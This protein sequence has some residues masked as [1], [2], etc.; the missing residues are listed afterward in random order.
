M[1]KNLAAIKTSIM[2]LKRIFIPF[3]FLVWLSA[4][5]QE[6]KT[7]VSEDG[8]STKPSAAQEEPFEEARFF[9]Y[10]G[11]GLG[12]RTGNILTGFLTSDGNGNYFPSTKDNSRFKNGFI[13]DFGGR[14]YFPN[15]FG[16]GLKTTHFMNQSKFL[17][18][19]ANDD[20][21]QFTYII[22]GMAEGLYRMY[23]SKE[24]KE[25]FVY[26]GLGLGIGYINQDQEYR[27]DRVTN[28]TETFFAFRPALG[29]NMPVYDVFHV[30][31]EGAYGFS[32]GEIN[33]GTLSLSQIQI[34]GG[35]NIRINP[36]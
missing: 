34:L 9:A 35:I 5:S 19:A 15:N 20:A 13:I 32:Q 36:F 23:F 4:Y 21:K 29:L 11:G 8:I 31:A 14:Y 17:Q 18:G 6:I 22:Y 25:G 7:K 1:A 28:V 12:I 30:Y 3:A 10:L 24:K 26:G 16:I 27:Y 2:Q 33:D